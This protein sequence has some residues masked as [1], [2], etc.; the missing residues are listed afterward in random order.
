MWQSDLQH[1]IHFLTEIVSSII[2]SR[3]SRQPVYEF[4]QANLSR[5]NTSLIKALPLSFDLMIQMLQEPVTVAEG[6]SLFGVLICQFPLGDH[7]LNLELAIAAYQLVLQVYSREM[8]PQQ[9][10]GIHNELAIA[11]SERIQGEGSDNIEQAIEICQLALQVF[12]YDS[13]P[14]QWAVTQNNLANAYY[15]QRIYGNYADNLEQAIVAYRKILIVYT[16][17]DFPQQWA[18][19]Q[20]NLANA[21]CERIHGEHA[22]N[23]EQAI[24]AYESVLQVF[25]VEDFP[26]QW[27]VTRHNLANA[28]H[29]RIRG[30]HADNL[31]RAIE[32]YKLALQVRSRHR[33]PQDW[34]MTQN[35]LANAYSERIR[36]KRAD[37][38]EH[39]IMSYKSALEV[40]TH[41][42]SPQD[43]AQTQNN[44]ANAYSERIKGER[45]DNL[46]QAITAYKLALKV[47]TRAASLRNWATTQHSLANA[48]SK[49]IRGNRSDNLEYAIERYK[50]ALQVQTREELPRDW[51]MT[52]L[53]L[54]RS[55]R[56]RIRG[57]QADNF[58]QAI[59]A[60]QLTLQVYTVESF[61]V[62]WAIVQNSLSIA[63]RK[64][65]RGN[66]AD[67]IE[68]SITA[69]KMALQELTRE[70]L[71]QDWAMAQ[72]NLAISYSNRVRGKQAENN[73]KA[74]EALSLSLQ[75]YTVE[76][77]PNDCRRISRDLG[78]IHF[79]K[80]NWEAAATA[81]STAFDAAKVLYQSCIFLDGKTTEIHE[82][83]GIPRLAAYT[84]ARTDPGRTKNLQAAISTL[85]QGRARGLSEAVERD[86]ANL[87]NLK[88]KNLSSQYK[89]FTAQIR[90]L[91]G[92]QR[93]RMVSSDRY[94]LT[95]EAM[96]REATAL[97]QKKN[98]LIR[99]IRKVPG[100]AN[101]LTLPTFKDVQKAAKRDCPLVYLIS[102]SAG[103]L[104]LIV[105]LKEIQSVWL[106]H[107]SETQLI[108]LL[109]KTWFAAYKQFKDENKT[110]PLKNRQP[111]FNAIDS[112]IHQLWQPLMQ[113]LIHHL[114]THNFNQAILI[115]TGYLSF[116]PLHAA[117]TENVT[118]PTRRRYALDDIHFTYAPNAKSLT[119]ARAIADHMQSD[120]ILA[121][122]NPCNDLPNSKREVS[123][124]VNSFRD[125]TTL[126]H[127]EAT[128][129]TVKAQLSEHAIAHFSCH[130]TANLTE[131]LTSGL[132]MSDGL[133]TLQDIFTLNLAE[134]GGLRLAILSACETG[135]QGIDDADE[136][137]SLPTG[138][139]QAGVA[140]VIAS[141]WPVDD[142]GTMTILTRFYDLWRKD[143]LEP[144]VALH[145]AQKWVRDTTSQ[146]K[147]KY[148]QATNPDLYQDLILLPPDH[149]AHPF[150]WAAFSYVGV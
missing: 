109:D 90:N 56:E 5:F 61:P 35:D 127:Q 124:A 12:R 68:H 126:S 17:E 134:T 98:A 4:F 111:W 8:F 58:E 105:T 27:A 106:D 120:S 96:R 123:A 59:A 32:G 114:K 77:F 80:Q 91:E 63:Y 102:T 83:A 87:E 11:Y 26:Q 14:Q 141:L 29:D 99:S 89:D 78:N 31:E 41:E 18:V 113:P 93:E 71:P 49:R 108:E 2:K 115:P 72:H 46:E 133:L 24:S 75:V 125:R 132:L 137:I 112:V 130:G 76:T 30:D 13:F 121:I 149:F 40:R 116:L 73:R 129:A 53:N 34:A 86:R 45:A 57:D 131:P 3:G 81:Y 117:W 70:S 110:S 67:N 69:C 101:F 88:D 119:T 16:S 23:L 55:Y 95:A 33:F 122:D 48:Y 36:G 150:Y 84:L 135:L 43:W 60:Y 22:D 145:Q 7:A 66:F 148:F 92:Q 54:A 44:L 85:E 51:A 139:L 140:A 79:N 144:A 52:T 118:Y 37:N 6:F 82:T 146:Q 21:Y 128:I 20:N 104:A 97:H 19:T 10:A 42:V 107:F 94:S 64:R 143:N 9:W 39:A 147:A 25:T 50:L 65:I 38:L 142:L 28:Y 62:N 103:S 1:E 74:I 15:Q 138:L 136:A 47:R 100:Y